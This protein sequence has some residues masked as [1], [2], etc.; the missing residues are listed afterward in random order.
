VSLRLSTALLLATAF[1]AS[2]SAQV[3]V[4]VGTPPIGYATIGPYAY[5]SYGYFGYYPSAWGS[6]WSNGLTLYGPPVPTYSAV[7]GAFGGSDQRLN[8]TRLYD[9]RPFAPR[10][11]LS[12]DDFVTVTFAEIDLKLPA[13]DAKVTVNGKALTETGVERSFRATNLP[14]GMTSRLTMHVTWTEGGQVKHAGR[15]IDVRG[16]QHVKVDLSR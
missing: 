4:G 10:G 15:D 5:Y 8:Y 3:Y 13:A 16:G 9:P 12:P 6:Q 2:A 7:A 14:Q 11:P 1:T